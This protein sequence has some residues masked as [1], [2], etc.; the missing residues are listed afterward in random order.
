[1]KIQLENDCQ[2]SWDDM[3]PAEGGRYCAQCTKVVTDF[4][5]L[6]TEQIIQKLS[7]HP[8]LCGRF[9][10]MQLDRDLIKPI[11]LAPRKSILAFV[12]AFV[13]FFSYKELNARDPKPAMEQGIA[14]ASPEPFT[15]YSEPSV[16][17]QTESVHDYRIADKPRKR[18]GG[19]HVAFRTRRK[20]FYWSRRFPFIRAESRI[21][22]YRMGSVR[23]LD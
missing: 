5:Y 6:S 20:T 19:S 10:A 15:V 18:R 1:M 2:Q 9:T 3:S 7:V 16:E 21:R 17:K 11:E 4:T 23:F 13:L 14:K 12:S 8:N 22:S